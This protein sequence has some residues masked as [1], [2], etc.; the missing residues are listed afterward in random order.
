ML[1]SAQTPAQQPLVD[2]LKKSFATFTPE[3]W[4]VAKVY[5]KQTNEEIPD[6]AEEFKVGLPLDQEITDLAK[7]GEPKAIAEVIN[8]RLQSSGILA[9]AGFKEGCL[10]VLLEST[11]VPDQEKVV[12]IL[13]PQIQ[14]LEIKSLKKLR[15]YG[16]QSGEDF[17][18][19]QEEVDFYASVDEANTTQ[20]P[21]VETLLIY[22]DTAQDSSEIILQEFD[23]IQLSNEIYSDLQTTCYQHLIYRVDSESDKTI[24]QIAEDFIDDLE[25]ELKLDID[26]FSRQFLII[27]EPFP[28]HIEISEIQTILSDVKASEFIGIKSAIRDLE[29]V[30]RE[31]IQTDFPQDSGFLEAFFLGATQELA[32]GIVGSTMLSREAVLGTAIGSLFAPGIGSVVGGAIGGWFGGKKQK[33]ELESLIERYENSRSRLFQEWEKVLKSI[34][35]KLNKVLTTLTSISLLPYEIMERA[36]DLCNEGIDFLEEEPQAAIE[37]FDKAIQLNPGLA[38]AWNNKGYVLNHLERFEE[39]LEILDQ[40][41]QIDPELVI[42]HNNLGDSLQS[43]GRID[44]AILSYNKILKIEPKNHAALCDLSKCLCRIEKYDEAL[45]AAQKLTDL[46]AENYLSWYTKVACYALLG[47]KKMALESLREALKLDLDESQKLAKTDSNIDNL[48][49]EDEFKSLMESAVGINYENLKSLLETKE[50]MEADK[51]TARLIRAI[52]RKTTDFEEVTQV[53]LNW[54]PCADLETI[55]S[56]WREHSGDQFGFSIQRKIYHDSSQDRDEFGDKTGWRIKDANGNA[57]WRSNTEFY[58]NVEASSKGHLP[59]SLWAG[60]DGWFENRRDRLIT[61]FER[62]DSCSIGGVTK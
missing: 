45:E 36:T 25:A 42:A 23:G 35:D 38:I 5:G 3:A 61:L 16:K 21:I 43:L 20:I 4:S 57:Y 47:N 9:K 13:L 7:Q 26:Q 29:R 41:L 34:Y 52:V 31:V 1:E 11:E 48:R 51:E 58:Y 18:D 12:S 53:A 39:A 24:H 30:T 60:E 14:K 37:L 40:A 15:L 10:Q 56:L 8:Q 59:S 46:D 17:P 28:I 19:W 50:W 32:S 22:D 27:I 54:F 6:W 55:D 49:D 44:E 2:S 62:I 33:K